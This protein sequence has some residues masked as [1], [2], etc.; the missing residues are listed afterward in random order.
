[1]LSEGLSGSSQIPYLYQNLL[2]SYYL[3]VNHVS[4]GDKFLPILYCRTISE[5]KEK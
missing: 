1:M 5:I 3:D 4:Q 2:E